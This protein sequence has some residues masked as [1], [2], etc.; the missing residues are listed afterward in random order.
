MKNSR[1]SFGNLFDQS[2]I[3]KIAEPITQKRASES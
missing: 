1:F 2:Q 3:S